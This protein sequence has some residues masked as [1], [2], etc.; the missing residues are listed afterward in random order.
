MFWLVIPQVRLEQIKQ[1][2]KR[3]QT[4]ENRAGLINEGQ[5]EE[6]AWLHRMNRQYWITK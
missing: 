6:K 3:R 1:L 5:R 2:R 4:K